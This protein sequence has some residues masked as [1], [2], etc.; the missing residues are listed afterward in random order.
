MKNFYVNDFGNIYTLNNENNPNSKLFQKFDS[1][2][3][4]SNTI[5]NKNLFNQNQ[6]K[7]IK[8]KNYNLNFKNNNIQQSNINQ[9]VSIPPNIKMTKNI[10]PK[11]RFNYMKNLNPP[12]MR[13]SSGANAVANKTK[14]AFYQHNYKTHEVFMNISNQNTQNTSNKNTNKNLSERTSLSV[15]KNSNNSNNNSN[16][17]IFQDLQN[18]KM[19]LSQMNFY[20][21]KNKNYFPDIHSQKQYNLNRKNEMYMHYS[22]QQQLLYNDFFDSLLRNPQ[23]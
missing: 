15:S 5:L 3:K 19:G 21:N 8:N 13:Y 18:R 17:N 2:N 12:Q 10:S 9:P 20:S 4:K 16:N 7:N 6:I 1:M 23:M 14:K 22:H 11:K